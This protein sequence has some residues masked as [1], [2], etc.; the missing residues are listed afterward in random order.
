M[1]PFRRP[2]TAKSETGSKRSATTNTTA[3][4]LDKRNSRFNAPVVAKPEANPDERIVADSY[5]GLNLV[6]QP[7]RTVVGLDWAVRAIEKVATGPRISS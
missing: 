6:L 1:S 4:A 2:W 5:T 3:E 7:L